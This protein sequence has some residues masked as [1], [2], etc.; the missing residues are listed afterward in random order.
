MVGGG[1]P[2][3]L[4][5]A[6]ARP[7]VVALSGLGRTL[8]DGRQ[9]EVRWAGADLAAQ[10]AV[11]REESRRCGTSPE[12]EAL[13]QIVTVTDDRPRALDELSE[14]LDGVPADDLGATPFVLVGT[15]QEMAAQLGRQADQL[16]ITRYVVRE[17]AVEPM[18]QVLSLI[19]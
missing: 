6:A 1:H 14:Q 7:D 3:V 12:I 13:V 5:A 9:H 11:V 17:P 16:G 18:T 4:R 15:V 19:N 8:P 10:L 2:Q